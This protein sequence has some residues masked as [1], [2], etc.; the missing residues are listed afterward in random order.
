VRPDTPE[1]IAERIAYRKACE[2]ARL[3]RQQAFPI[4]TAENFA[5]K[6]AFQNRRIA[7]LMRNQG[8]RQ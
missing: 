3:E 8:Q 4:I 1:Q 2:Q 6:D 5:E 7:E